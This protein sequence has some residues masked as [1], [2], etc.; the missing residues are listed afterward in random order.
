MY[1]NVEFAYK[2]L[3]FI[4]MQAVGKRVCR[5]QQ[6]EFRLFRSIPIEQKSC[7]VKY[8]LFKRYF[9]LVRIDQDYI[10]CKIYFLPNHLIHETKNYTFFPNAH[11]IIC[12]V[13]T[14][15]TEQHFKTT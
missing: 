1:I 9:R 4:G 2:P 10:L 15:I 3:L 12:H 7:F 6:C 5:F 8:W 13:C 14:G 11:A